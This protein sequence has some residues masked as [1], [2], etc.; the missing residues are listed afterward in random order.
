MRNTS[1]TN[2]CGLFL[3]SYKNTGI[4]Y[5][6]PQLTRIPIDLLLWDDN[7]RGEGIPGITDGVIHETNGSHHLTNLRQS[8]DKHI[9]AKHSSAC[10][11]YESQH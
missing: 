5:V 11:E 9:S 2:N 6:K 4:L 1:I 8:K 3:W 7:L 10:E